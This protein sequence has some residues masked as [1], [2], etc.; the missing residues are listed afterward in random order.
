MAAVT[1]ESTTLQLWLGVLFFV[2]VKHPQVIVT[3]SVYN[4]A[5]SICTKHLEKKTVRVGIDVWC[6]RVLA[7][8]ASL[9]PLVTQ[10]QAK[11]KSSPA[12]LRESVGVSAHSSRPLRCI[13]H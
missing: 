1:E 7:A 6:L 3:N 4:Q 8:L 11:S 10:E 9:S 12:K 5:I 2:C 13:R